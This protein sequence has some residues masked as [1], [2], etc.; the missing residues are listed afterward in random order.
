MSLRRTP[1]NFPH[2][3]HRA[4][5]RTGARLTI[6]DAN[7]QPIASTHTRFRPGLLQ[8]GK[9]FGLRINS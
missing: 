1:D 4:R 2:M 7:Y 9:D 6:W 8:I 3:K 5:K